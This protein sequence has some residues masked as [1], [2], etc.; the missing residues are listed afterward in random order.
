MPTI[1][2]KSKEQYLAETISVD[3]CEG[4]EAVV[5][6]KQNPHFL[7]GITLDYSMVCTKC[8][9]ELVLKEVVVRTLVPVKK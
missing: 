8:G 9:K 1:I 3:C 5:L 6:V 7:S 4:A 2:P